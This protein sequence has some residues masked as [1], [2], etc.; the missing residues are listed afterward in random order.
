LE[1]G[2]EGAQNVTVSAALP[3]GLQLVS[4]PGELVFCSLFGDVS[5]SA[6]LL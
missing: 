3:S 2:L 4:T 6:M 5:M 1:D